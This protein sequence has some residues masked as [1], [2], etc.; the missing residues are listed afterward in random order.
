MPIGARINDAS[1]MV[2]RC[3]GVQ[4]FGTIGC[5]GKISEGNVNCRGTLVTHRISEDFTNGTRGSVQD[6]LS[7]STMQPTCDGS[8]VVQTHILH[9]AGG[10]VWAI[11][12]PR[13]YT[14]PNAKRLYFLAT[15]L[16]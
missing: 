13:T 10:D 5:A 14:Q 1:G 16:Q 6:N 4:K 12:A 11:Q 15:T 2:D 3:G 7:S 9:A 8:A